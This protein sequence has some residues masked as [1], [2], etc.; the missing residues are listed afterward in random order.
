VSNNRPKPSRYLLWSLAFAAA[1]ASLFFAA[2]AIRQRPT[3][4][5]FG[6]VPLQE[7]EALASA[8]EIP[9]LSSAAPTLVSAEP[10]KAN[11]AE[12]PVLLY[13]ALNDAWIAKRGKPFIVEKQGI[14]DCVSWAGKHSCDIHTAVLWKIGAIADWKE[15]ASEPIY[16]G[17]RVEARQISRGGYSDGATGYH[18]AKWLKE[19]GVL[20]RQDYG[21]LVD[22][23]QY[24]SARA[25]DWGN[26]GCGGR[27]DA[28]RLDNIAREHPIRTVA[29]CPSYAEAV[30]AIKNGYPILVCSNVGFE[31]SQ[32]DAEGFA[33]RNGHW[34]HAMC[35][36]AVRFDRPGLL[37]L[38]SWGPRYITG[39]KWPEDQPDGSFWV[40]Q[41]TADYMLKGG[42]FPS[43]DSYA[44]SGLDGFKPNV[45]DHEKW[46]MPA[47]TRP[48]KAKAM[49]DNGETIS[50]LAL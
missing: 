1:S 2:E 42:G 39:G 5:R 35:F 32:R 48:P 4:N 8:A 44:I 16:G 47:P 27:D 13:R 7:S 18:A 20:Y 46:V 45:I 41:Q 21:G 22:L 14:G 17:A 11:A 40:D 50:T 34:A 28:G 49:H 36:V 19:W 12:P 43:S 30:A 33:D 25:K 23:S 38:N 6:Y 31:G 3:D 24:S 15:A 29:A 26:F 37:C 10:L 9:R